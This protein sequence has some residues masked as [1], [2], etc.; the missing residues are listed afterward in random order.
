[1]PLYT[2]LKGMKLGLTSLDQTEILYFK[3]YKIEPHAMQYREIWKKCFNNEF[4]NELILNLQPTGL[5]VADCWD[6]IIYGV[7]LQNLP[8]LRHLALSGIDVPGILNWQSPIKS[9]SSKIIAFLRHIGIEEEDV[10]LVEQYGV[11]E[12]TEQMLI[13]LGLNEMEEKCSNTEV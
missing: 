9:A 4:S 1:M 5:S 7:V 10:R 13:D 2:I 6:I 8:I 11:D 3:D 12:E